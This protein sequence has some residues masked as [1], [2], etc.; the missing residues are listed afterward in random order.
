MTG[1]DVTEKLTRLVGAFSERRAN[2]SGVKAFKRLETPENPCFV[3][4]QRK[5]FD[6]HVGIFLDG[7]IFHLHLR[8]VEFQPLCV[9]RAYFK[10][11]RY[12]R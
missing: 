11:I 3:V 8:G 6:P 7:R 5:G 10:T 12:Y 9:A 2:L 1:E 4:M